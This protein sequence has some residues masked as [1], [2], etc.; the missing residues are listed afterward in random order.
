MDET[1]LFS[2]EIL[3]IFRRAKV[4]LLYDLQH[5]PSVMYII[6]NNKEEPLTDDEKNRIKND[7][8][9]KLVDGEIIFME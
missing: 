5:C 2:D 1:N 8:P 4:F 6:S 9:F 7:Y 3:S